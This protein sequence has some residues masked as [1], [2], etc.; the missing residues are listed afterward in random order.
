MQRGQPPQPCVLMTSKLFESST[1]STF[2]TTTGF[3][4]WPLQAVAPYCQ[5]ACNFILDQALLLEG[6]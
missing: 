5:P 3:H 6:N 1:E 4:I 2:T